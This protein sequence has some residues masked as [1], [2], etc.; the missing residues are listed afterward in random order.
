MIAAN[1]IKE[2]HPKKIVLQTLGI[3]RSSYYYKPKANGE[4]KGRVKSEFTLKKTGE[5]IDNDQV[6]DDIK[7]IL[8]QEFVDYGYLKVTYWLREEKDYIINPKKV[9][10]LMGEQGL[11]NKIVHRRKSRR[12]WVK[13]LLPPATDAFEYLEFD[14]K[15]MYVAGC[16]RNALLLSVIDVYSRWVLGQHMDWQIKKQQVIDL[17]DQLFA[18]YPLPKH[19]YVRNDN[20]SQFE[21]QSVQ[22]YFEEKGVVQEFCKPATPE[23]NAH[24]ESYHSIIERV[25]CQRYE[26]ESLE[27]LQETMNRFI[28]FYDFRRIHSGVGYTSP[29]NYLLKKGI[30][31]SQYDLKQ[32]LDCSA[33]GVCENATMIDT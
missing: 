29:F 9:Y 7:E 19:F 24:I 30:D 27:E 22:E 26:L 2:G 5:V 12:N 23:Q 3:P 4:K 8:S 31:L 21:A 1:F 14:I 16:N 13:E 32:A 20:G 15:Y 6:V 25:V 10:R 33:S 17:F 11:L 28:Q 18:I